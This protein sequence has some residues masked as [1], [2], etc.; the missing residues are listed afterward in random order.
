VEVVR[1]ASALG[2]SL[3]FSP[4][5][6]PEAGYTLDFPLVDA[7]AARGMTRELRVAGDGDRVDW[8]LGSFYS[9]SER[10]YGQ[11]AYAENYVAVSGPAVT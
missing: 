4:F 3:S 5:G 6:T 2:G 8:V 1:D 11:S 10:Q 9:T 7:T